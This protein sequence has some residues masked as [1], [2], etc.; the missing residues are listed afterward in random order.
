MNFEEITQRVAA[1]RAQIIKSKIIARATIKQ[2]GK[3]G[4][5]II[6]AFELSKRDRYWF[7]FRAK[8]ARSPR[9]T[10]EYVTHLILWQGKNTTLED[11][12][13]RTVGNADAKITRRYPKGKRIFTDHQDRVGNPMKYTAP[14]TAPQGRVSTDYLNRKLA[15]KMRG[16]TLAGWR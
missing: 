4:V 9:R 3:E 2:A 15:R 10:W 5:T 8:T 1:E 14:A 11:M 12:I 7:I 13:T 6:A 16:H